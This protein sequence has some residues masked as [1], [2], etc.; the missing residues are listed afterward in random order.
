MRDVCCL[1]VARRPAAQNAKAE[2]KRAVMIICSVAPLIT[3]QRACGRQKEQLRERRECHEVSLITFS[4]SESSLRP[5][6]VQK[7]ALLQKFQL[8]DNK[9]VQL[10]RKCCNFLDKREQLDT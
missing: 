8:N 2:M 6:L 7:I 4:L 1:C 10:R 9:I 3:K 5:Q